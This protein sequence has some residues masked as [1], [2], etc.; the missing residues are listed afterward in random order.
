[1]NFLRNHHGSSEG[2]FIQNFENVFIGNNTAFMKSS[3]IV[4]REFIIYAEKF[5]KITGNYFESVNNANKLEL[6]GAF[7]DVKYTNATPSLT[8]IIDKNYAKMYAVLQD[9]SYN[10]QLTASIGDGV[11]AIT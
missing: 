9:T 6:Y 11:T 1:L 2:I 10:S 4:N 3:S 5:L 8:M 7:R